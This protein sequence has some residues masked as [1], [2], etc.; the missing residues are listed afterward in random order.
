MN[1][2]LHK[3]F[4]IYSFQHCIFSRISLLSF[5]IINFVNSPIILHDTFLD[6]L[7]YKSYEELVNHNSNTRKLRN[8]KILKSS[9]P[10]DKHKKRTFDYFSSVFLDTFTSEQ[11]NYKFSFFKSFLNNNINILFNNFL[12]SFNLVNL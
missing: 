4:N 5:K 3:K 7:L 1:D 10:F 2:F 6:N 12:S 9:Y 11:I 8:G